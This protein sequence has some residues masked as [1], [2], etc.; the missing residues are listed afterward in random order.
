MWPVAIEGFPYIGISLGLTLISFLFHAVSLTVFFGIL[1]LFVLQFFRNPSRSG[2]QEEGAVLSPADGEI[3]SIELVQEDRFL[4]EKAIK[5][6]IFMNVFNVHVNRAPYTGTVRQI[7][8]QPGRFFAANAEKASLENEQNAILLETDNGKKILFIQIAGL[9]A[10]RIICYAKEGDRLV[11]GE[12][13]G[14]IKFGSRVDLYLPP[15]FRASVKLK[16][17]VK[18]GETTIGV[19]P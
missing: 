19:L 5:V 16:D 8:Y 17:R 2:S 3:I 4:R 7:L 15:D 10:R 9:I 18:A 1:S 13:C 14:I 12:R 11:K 6:S